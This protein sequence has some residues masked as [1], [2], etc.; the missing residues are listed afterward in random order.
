MARGNKY[1][2]LQ[3]QFEKDV[4]G[5]FKIIRGFADIR[6]LAKISV[7]YE[8]SSTPSSGIVTG[9]QREIDQEHAED[10]RKYLEESDYR[11]FPEIVLSVRTTIQD[12]T[13]GVNILGVR[14][15]G[16]DGIYLSRRWKSKNIRVHQIHIDK[17]KINQIKE[18]KRIRRVDGNHRLKLADK[19]KT[20]ATVPKKY[21]APFCLI[22]LNPPG[23]E[24]DDYAESL[25]FHTINSTALRLESE[26]SLKL[27]L[28]QRPEL[29]MTATKEFAYSPE[30]YLT[31]L[32]KDWTL[33]LPQPA[34][35]RLG[36]RPLTALADAA[37]SMLSLYPSLKT[38]LELL[39]KFSDDLF[40][41]L[42]DIV[43]RLAAVQPSLC[44]AEYF[45]ELASRIWT[46]A[47]GNTHQE[48]TNATVS[49]LEK[50]GAWANKIGLT[51][52]K[53]GTSLSDQLLN[54]FR[55][56][57]DK[58][59]RKV[60]LARW[61]PKPT[62]DGGAALPK[63]DLRLQE[64]RRAIEDLYAAGISLT[65]VDMGTQTG[66]TF[67]IHNEMYN[68]IASSDI[69]LIDLTGLRANVCIEAGYALKHHEK[70]RL[71]FMF[72]KSAP[73]HDKVPFDLTTFRYEEFNDA[74]EIIAKIKPHIEAIIE[75][76]AAGL[77]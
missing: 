40:A 3:G 14:S 71:I 12:E 11:F 44:Q 43:T 23:D 7:P 42:N 47:E 27:I 75:N 25:I 16:E 8:M 46:T 35:D 48:R 60:F 54:F 26:H 38:D 59:P 29:S 1:I 57:Q 28:G 61:Y 9:H 68:A 77:I 65:L 41:G 20:D 30:L 74:A 76:A 49:T 66:G 5:I 73:P 34:R 2:V 70:G 4:L 13:D 17:Y 58:I 6:D 62:D 15:D 24:A 56:V 18:Q 31:R 52:L 51:N 67:P 45:V 21:L 37:R 10:I 69:I 39:R 22:L 33:R 50:F 32:L 63:A 72:Q 19:L 55:A 53:G 36:N 64:I